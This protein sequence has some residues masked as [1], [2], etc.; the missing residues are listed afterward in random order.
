MSN[1]TTIKYLKVMD[2]LYEINHISFF[3][4]TLEASETDLTIN[5]VPA[6]KMWDIEDFK[7]FKVKLINNG[8]RAEIVDFNVWKSKRCG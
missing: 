2:K 8:G 1:N 4:M 3:Y 5:D 6:D 7:N